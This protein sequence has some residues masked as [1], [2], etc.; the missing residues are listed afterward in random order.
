MSIVRIHSL[1]RVSL[2]GMDNV[3]SWA[4]K[5]GKLEKRTGGFA[6]YCVKM[7]LEKEFGI[8]YKAEVSSTWTPMNSSM[9]KLGWSGAAGRRLLNSIASV[10]L[11]FTRSFHLVK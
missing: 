6:C 4:R 9:L 11:T 7:F 10:L 3:E 8:E 5:G 2:L 1:Y